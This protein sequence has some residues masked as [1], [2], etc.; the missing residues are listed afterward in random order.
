MKPTELLKVATIAFL[1]SGLIVGCQQSLTSDDMA[2]EV[3]A[4]E[5]ECQGATQFMQPS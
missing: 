2:T 1:A 5:D 3:A 4:V